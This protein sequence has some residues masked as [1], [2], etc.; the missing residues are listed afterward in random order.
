MKQVIAAF[1]CGAL[2][3]V[4]LAAAEMTDP[5]RVTGFLDLAGD[6]DMT[7]ALVMASALTV[8]VPLFPLVL[9]RPHPLLAQKFALPVK[10]AVDRQLLAGAMIFG[11]GWGLA[12]LCP[13]PAIAALISGSPGIFA[14]VAA[15]IAGQWLA[16]R[17]MRRSR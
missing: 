17:L 7:L 9:K 4:G 3:G 5:A 1:F 8:S 2:F 11:I 16:G 12:G 10:S 15:M 6:W 14:F 13:G